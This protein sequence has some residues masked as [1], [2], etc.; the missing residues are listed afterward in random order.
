MLFKTTFNMNPNFA[1]GFQQN[2]FPKMAIGSVKNGYLHGIPGWQF[3]LFQ[4]A[5]IFRGIRC[6][7]EAGNVSTR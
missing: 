1:F 7:E 2:G 4:S 6:Q 5:T 3:L